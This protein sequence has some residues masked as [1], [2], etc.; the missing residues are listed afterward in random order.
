MITRYRTLCVLIATTLYLL[1]AF[2]ILIVQVVAYR[3][4]MAYCSFV[5]LKY[6]FVGGVSQTNATGSL[7]RGLS[8][9]YA[10]FIDAIDGIQF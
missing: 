7:S 10:R 4:N 1:I 2:G 9:T 5:F 8:N 3:D 6:M